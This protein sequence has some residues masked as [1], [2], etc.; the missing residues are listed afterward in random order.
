M[1]HMD[2]KVV[3]HLLVID[4]AI[5]LVSQRKRKVSREKKAAIN[6]EVQNITSTYFIIE[7]KYL[8]WLTNMG[9]IRN[10]SNK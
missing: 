7:V 9:L 3:F 5:K 1:P 8:S 2:T 4:H 6:E 10:G